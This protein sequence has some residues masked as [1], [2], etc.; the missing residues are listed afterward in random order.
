MKISYLVTV[1]NETTTFSNLLIRLKFTIG[2]EDEI[3]IVLDSNCKNNDETKHLISDF[4]FNNVKKLEHNLNNNYSEHKNWGANQ[5]SGDFIFQIDGDELPSDLLILNIKE[6]INA[7]P[8]I[9]TFWVSRINDF[10][11]VSEEHAKRWGWKLSQS[12]LYNRP[13]INWPDPQGRIFKHIPTIKWSG[14]LHERLTGNN[15]FAYLPFDEELAL[16]HD[17]TIEK[18]LET[19][20]RYNR[21]FTEKENQGFNLPK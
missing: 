21:D 2:E 14:R 9:E 17:K 15:T 16:Y 11:G 13:I 10:K 12:T 8:N 6:I 5:C 19:N 4:Q 1:S 3:V 7:N 20:L 18:Q